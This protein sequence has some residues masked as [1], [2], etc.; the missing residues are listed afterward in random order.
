[1]VKGGRNSTPSDNGTQNQVNK[2]VKKSNGIQPF[3]FTPKERPNDVPTQIIKT[4][5][6]RIKLKIKMNI[7]QGDE[8]PEQLTVY[9]K[10]FQDKIYKKIFL[11][12]PEK[13][14][15]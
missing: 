2:E 15:F 13:L 4:T 9:L 8:T 12:A 14:L 1:M 7:L 10:N 6:E 3:L 11:T 5:E